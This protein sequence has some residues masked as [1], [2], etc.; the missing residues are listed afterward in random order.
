MRIARAGVRRVPRRPSGQ[1]ATP[2]ESST[3]YRG[4]RRK[5]MNATRRRHDL[6]VPARHHVVTARRPCRSVVAMR[7]GAC[8][9]IGLQR[10]EAPSMYEME[11]ASRSN[12]LTS[13]YSGRD[14][15]EPATVARLS[16]GELRSRRGAHPPEGAFRSGSPVGGPVRGLRSPSARYR[17]LSARCPLTPRFPSEPGHRLRW[18]ARFLPPRED[19]RKRLDGPISKILCGVSGHPQMKRRYPQAGPRYPPVV[20]RFIH[21]HGHHRVS[22]VVSSLRSGS[23]GPHRGGPTRMLHR[24]RSKSSR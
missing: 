14:S 23:P 10:V 18:R 3:A 20:H 6:I 15:A 7:R 21:T 4:S 11:G 19:L 1:R 13:D 24:Y 17:E 16:L 9:N 22:V 8:G 2:V 5:M 12:G